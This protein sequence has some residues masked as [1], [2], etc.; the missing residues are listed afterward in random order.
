[1]SIK[2]AEP[3]IKPILGKKC[4]DRRGKGKNHI[5]MDA[6]KQNSLLECPS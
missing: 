1:M 6:Y 2:L 3:K 5:N 4:W